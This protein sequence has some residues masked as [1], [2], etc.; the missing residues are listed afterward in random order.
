MDSEESAPVTLPVPEDYKE[1]S[2]TI[3]W[4][5]GSVRILGITRYRSPR[6]RKTGR[7]REMLKWGT[8]RR[9]TSM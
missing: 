5:D 2:E 3:P 4:R 8:G 9:Y 7:D 6:R 1:L